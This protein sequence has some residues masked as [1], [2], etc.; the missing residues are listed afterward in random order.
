MLCRFSYDSWDA[1]PEIQSFNTASKIPLLF[2]DMSNSF[3]HN[4]ATVYSTASW[5][6]ASTA[7]TPVSMLYH[8][9]NS[10]NTLLRAVKVIVVYLPVWLL[11]GGRPAA[12][13]LSQPGV[14]ERK[15]H[16]ERN[17]TPFLQM[18]GPVSMA[19]QK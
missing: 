8:P 4:G 11:L 3:S 1:T 6:L 9:A 18:E 16:V 15:A 19:V 14:S 17:Y 5:G 12:A 2:E 13:C 10:I 7:L